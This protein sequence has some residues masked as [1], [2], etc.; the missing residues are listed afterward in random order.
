MTSSLSRSIAIC[1]FLCLL[2]APL[3]GQASPYVVTTTADNAGAPTLGMLRFAILSRNACS[4]VCPAITFA[5]PN[6]DPGCVSGTCTITL[7]ASLPNINAAISPVAINGQSQVTFNGF[8]ILINGNG[9]AGDGILA[10][11]SVNLSGFYIGGFPTGAAVRLG[12][13]AD[14]STIST[15]VIG[16][17]PTFAPFPNQN[18]ITIETGY[19]GATISAS[20]RS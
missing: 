10:V 6:T 16:F 8:N 3:F 11:S 14:G 17:G 19:T 18:G 20:I 1:A 2:T 15:L 9:V 12:S 13:N 5:I 7:A 4:T